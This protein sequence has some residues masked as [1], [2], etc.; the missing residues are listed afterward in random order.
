VDLKKKLPLF[1]CILTLD[2][3]QQQKVEYLNL[4][5][6]CFACPTQDH[7]I[8]DCPHWKP[9]PIASKGAGVVVLTVTAA[10]EIDSSVALGQATKDGR[11]LTKPTQS[12]SGKPIWVSVQE[13]SWGTRGQFCNKIKNPS[14]A[15]GMFVARVRAL[16]PHLQ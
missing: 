14:Q 4:P 6:V 12:G 13:Y 7:L 1:I 3:V 16:P 15:S 9:K 8:H 11:P 10:N 2:G 5:N